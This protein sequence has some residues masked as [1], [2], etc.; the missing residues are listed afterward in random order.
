M[1]SIKR[2][3][4]EEELR[5]EVINIFNELIK[6]TE[7]SEALDLLD[8]LPK[9]L[10]YHNKNHT[11]DVMKE[12]ILFALADKLDR[13]NLE[14]QVISASWHDVGYLKKYKDNEPVAVEIFK[15]SK[16]YKLIGEQDKA[17][18]IANILDTQMIIKQDEPFFL[19][20]RSKFGYVLDADLS[21]FGRKDF[22]DKESK[23]IEEQGLDMLN[24]ET[25]KKFY[26]FAI[27]LLKNHDWKTE[28]AKKFRQKQKE[29]NLKKLEEEYSKLH[30]LTQA[31][32][33]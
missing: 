14:L 5:P 16:A 22:F 3:I 4:T 28:S 12:T 8:S 1:E 30:L 18:I 13:K 2:D 11:I 17:E 9:N 20:Q 31:D 6:K 25:K 21:N 26:A 33:L 15:G 24:T 23:V 10:K 7:I 32:A 19:K 27:E 29:I